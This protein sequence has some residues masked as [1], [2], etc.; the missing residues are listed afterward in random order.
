LI[1][2]SIQNKIDFSVYANNFYLEAKFNA[3]K[4]DVEKDKDKPFVWLTIKKSENDE[5]EL[6]KKDIH[7]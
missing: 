3:S 2:D 4:K 5:P 1:N 7:M 6:I